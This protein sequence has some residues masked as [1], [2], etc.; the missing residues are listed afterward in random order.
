MTSSASASASV[1]IPSAINGHSTVDEDHR[2]EL[3]VNGED[4]VYP[5][6][7]NFKL[8]EHPVDQIRSL[9]VAVIGAG[10]AGITAGALLPVKVPGIELTILEKNA[11]VG[12]TWY[13]K[14]C[15]LPMKRHR[16]ECN[17]SL[18]R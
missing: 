4:W 6:P 14:P 2:H 11:D 1:D 12:G 17:I 18:Y 7:T 16:R 13:G 5:Y 10:I 9:K 15:A 3:A 8:S